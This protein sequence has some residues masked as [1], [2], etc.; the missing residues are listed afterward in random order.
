MK[1]QFIAFENHFNSKFYIQVG[2]ISSNSYQMKKCMSKD[3]KV[4]KQDQIYCYE[5]GLFHL[6]GENP[7]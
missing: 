6:N 5:R 4:D 3:F 7:I 2:K 1:N